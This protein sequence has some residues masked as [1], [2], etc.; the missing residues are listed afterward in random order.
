MSLLIQV[1]SKNKPVI[2]TNNGFVTIS[3]DSGDVILP[4]K[5]VKLMDGITHIL[6]D[7]K[8][9]EVESIIDK[10][11]RQKKIK[12][13]A[14]K[15]Q[16]MGYV[17][18]A[19]NVWYPIEELNSARSSKLGGVSKYLV[20]GRVVNGIREARCSCYSFRYAKGELGSLSKTCKHIMDGL[21]SSNNI[22]PHESVF[23]NN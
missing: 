11:I 8:L 5:V 1:R 4:E 14:I 21:A 17:G 22:W 15:R 12:S 19:G 2:L 18:T 3:L 6:P 23:S 16:G 13:P 7:G 20:E 10:A 9:A